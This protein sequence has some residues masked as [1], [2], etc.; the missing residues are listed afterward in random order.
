MTA[1]TTLRLMS[2]LNMIIKKEVI[3]MGMYTELVLGVKIKPVKEVAQKL[4]YMLH[5]NVED[6]HFDHPLF[7][8]KTRWDDML[9]CDSYY[10]DGQT[11]SKLVYDTFIQSYYLNVRCNLKNYYNEIKLFL[12]WLCPYIETDGFL[13]YTRYEEHDDPTLIYKENGKIVYK[14]WR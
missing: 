4:N 2:A 8:D 1:S 13:G 7:S 14:D 3:T 5:E 11:D 6:I 9:L 12:D 10:F